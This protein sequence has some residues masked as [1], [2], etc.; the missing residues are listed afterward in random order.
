[1]HA[2]TTDETTHRCRRSPDGIGLLTRAAT[3]H[4][5]DR[6]PHVGCRRPL[7]L[8]MPGRPWIAVHMPILPHQDPRRRHD[9]P[10][11]NGD[12]RSCCCSN[13]NGRCTVPDCPSDARSS[14][15]IAV[16]IGYPVATLADPGS[17]RRIFPTA[18]LYRSARCPVARKHSF[19][20]CGHLC[21]YPRCASVVALGCAGP[22]RI[23]R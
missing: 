14:R 10:D 15:P 8:Q 7:R 6:V 9:D 13:V 18:I 17:L 21:G 22:Y 4:T 5:D 16:H 20:T 3:T 1:M 2:K 19:H 23:D 11:R 12:R